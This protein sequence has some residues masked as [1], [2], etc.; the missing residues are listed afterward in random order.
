MFDFSS[1]RVAILIDSAN[2][3]YALSWGERVDY[4]K[5]IDT[6]L[7]GRKLVRVIAYV[8]S[9]EGSNAG[10]FISAL[11]SQGVEAKVYQRETGDRHHNWDVGIAVDAMLVAKHA[12]TIVVAS[13]DGDF[14]YLY[15]VLRAMGLRVEVASFPKSLSSSIL[16]EVDKV[17]YLDS[18]CTFQKR[19][20]E[21]KEAEPTQAP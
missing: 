17:H 13:G 16:N 11:Q 5:V 4:G 2:L 8:V 3:F 14:L 18:D 21:E 20:D 10:K 15:R 1:Q 7:D 6:I 19:T 12:D 9:V